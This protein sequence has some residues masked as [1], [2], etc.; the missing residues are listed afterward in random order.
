MRIIE[1]SSGVEYQVN[2]GDEFVGDDG[3]RYFACHLWPIKGAG[4][5]VA[6]TV[7]KTRWYGGVDMDAAIRTAMRGNTSCAGR[8]QF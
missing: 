2:I 1:N 7:A 5:N 3:K 4:V 6:L 8:F